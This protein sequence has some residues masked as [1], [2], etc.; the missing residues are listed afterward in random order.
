ME[1]DIALIATGYV[2]TRI[3]MFA[4][5]G[6][7]VYRVLRTPPARVLIKANRNSKRR[8]SAGIRTRF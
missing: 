2:L 6:Y 5:F 4:A 1:N 7:L 3:G 8:H